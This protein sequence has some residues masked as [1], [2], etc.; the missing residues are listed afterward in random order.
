MKKA[1][2]IIVALILIQTIWLLSDSTAQ[3]PTW[4]D[5]PMGRAVFMENAG[6]D[7][8]AYI[9]KLA[10]GDQL[11][12]TDG[13]AGT[14][15]LADLVNLAG[16]VDWENVIVV[17]KSG[18]DYT[19]I[20]AGLAAAG[21]AATSSNPYV[22][23]V[24]PGVYEEGGGTNDLWV[25]DYVT[26]RGWSRD[27]V[28]IRDTGTTP[29]TENPASG[30]VY[31]CGQDARLEDI[32]VEQ[33]LGVGASYANAITVNRVTQHDGATTITNC[34]DVDNMAIRNVRA[35]SAGNFT[36]D[37]FSYGSASTNRITVD[38]L[39][40]TANAFA[41][42]TYGSS[43]GGNSVITVKN[44]LLRATQN[45]A[46][47]EEALWING[48]GKLIFKN[49]TIW[50]TY[51]SGSAVYID[52]DF[53]G[54]VAYF[55][56]CQFVTGAARTPR[57][58]AFDCVASAGG[59]AYVANALATGIT[60]TGG[61]AAGLTLASVDVSY[62]ITVVNDL[63]VDNAVTVTGISNLNG[64]IKATGD[65]EVIVD[66]DNNGTNNFTIKDGAGKGVFVVN[67]DRTITLY[68]TDGTTP[69]FDVSETGAISIANNTI[70]DE[71]IAATIGTLQSDT[72]ATFRKFAADAVGHAL[73]FQK[74]RNTTPGSHTI[75]QSGDAI[76]TINFAGSDGTNFDTAAQIE[77]QVGGTPG[78]GT[79]MPGKLIFRVSPDASATPADALTINADKTIASVNTM[80]ATLST[81]ANFNGFA[82][83][84][85]SA[86]T[87]ARAG[88]RLDGSGGGGGFS[89]NG[90]GYT[91]VADW[92]DSL[93]VQ[94]DSGLDG[95][96]VLYSADKVR[97]Q[98]PT[99]GTNALLVQSGNTTAAGTFK[100]AGYQSSDGSAGQ[101]VTVTINDAVLTATPHTL[102]FKNG[103]LTSYTAA[104]P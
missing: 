77:A 2:S 96:I 28:I 61:G 23:L 67:E 59:T 5:V 65:L 52:Q 26:L 1:F 33:L 71:N 74:S 10:S 51:G 12:F 14:V 40:S 69:L 72:T 32:T 81:D 9:E 83:S 48:T 94:V 30:I 45:S 42:Q 56:G 78:A 63:T 85:M 50:D 4:K 80:T 24:M 76:A 92:Q 21:A 88:I 60:K 49:V 46:P 89:V 37:L 86:G 102:V 64:G 68:D 84:N 93:T 70:I 36:V 90:G 47:N 104:T 87:S 34:G 58:A 98:S 20:A 22:V 101:T 7:K 17:A 27:S 100:A 15:V 43:S 54:F 75:V 57:T 53:T 6:D 19:T 31:V 44:S 62:N 3:T 95:G 73:T 66:S 97:I 29:V 91:G 18:G 41:L 8:S 39:Y 103:L 25:K 16:G 38:G 13:T 99:A 11:Q 35:I 55:D 79:D 82:V